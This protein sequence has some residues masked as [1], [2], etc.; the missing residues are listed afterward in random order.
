VTVTD[1]RLCLQYTPR[2]RKPRHFPSLFRPVSDA[3]GFPAINWASSM[4]FVITYRDLHH[5][6][7]SG[8][9]IVFSEP[10]V[11]E[12]LER[13]QSDGCEVTSITPRPLS[14]V[15]SGM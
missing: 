13:L 1:G 3:V 15:V 4:A 8:A 14:S 7:T 5:P 10:Q 9:K 2:A 11:R 12:A 6:G